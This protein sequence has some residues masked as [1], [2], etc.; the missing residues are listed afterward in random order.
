MDSRES[1]DSVDTST[2]ANT[3]SRVCEE[4]GIKILK[5]RLKVLPDTTLCVK[6]AAENE[7][8]TGFIPTLLDDYDPAELSGMLSPDD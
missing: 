3:K 5:E 6:C 8:K 4:C 7:S 1:D 2:G